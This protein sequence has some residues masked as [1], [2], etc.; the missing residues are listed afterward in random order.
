MKRWACS[1]ICVVVALQLYA[2]D[3]TTCSDSHFGHV[4]RDLVSKGNRYYM[5]SDREGIREVVDS[6]HGF[7]T[8]R[9]RS[10]RLSRM[11]SLEYVADWYKLCGNYHYENSFYDNTPSDSA[12][13]YY[14]KALEIY[15]SDTAFDEDLNCIPMIHRELAQL[16]YKQKNYQEAY[17]HT[18][19][20]Y[21]A[22][23]EALTHDVI[24]EDDA[25]YLDIQTQ[26]ALCLARMGDTKKALGMINKMTNRYP[27]ADEMYGEALRKKAKILMLQEENGGKKKRAAALKCYRSFFSLKKEDALARFMGMSSR[28]REQ[29][30][31]RIRPFVTDCYRLEDAD[32]G[33]LYDVTLFAKGLLL[34]LNGAGGGRQQ[35]HTT[36]Q[37][38][39][40]RLKPDACAIEFVQY[41]KYGQQQMA[42]LVLKKTGKPVFVKM[43]A[44]D[45]VWNYIVADRTVED[46]LQR[47][48]KGNFDAINRVYNDSTGIY[49][50]IWNQE[51]LGAIG[52]T[53]RVYFAPDGY[54][55]RIAIEY[56]L[57]QEARQW[58][59][60]RLTSTRRL[61]DKQHVTDRCQAL[62]IGGVDFAK[63][64]A[65][66]EGTNDA[67]A[68]KRMVNNLFTPLN[69][70]K[71]EVESILKDRANP[72]DSLLCGEWA[73]EQTFR[74]LCGKYPVIHVSAHGEYNADAPLGTDIKA[75]LTD[76]S[77]SE[78]VIV[79]AGVNKTLNDK[80]FDP[81]R[82]QDGILSAK[83]LSTLDMKGVQLVVLACCETGLGMV[84]ADGVFGIQR[85]L[86]N[87]GVGAIVMTL[88]E[89]DDE[90]T[91]AFMTTFH[92]KICEGKSIGCAF[93]ETREKY[94]AIDDDL[95]NQPCYLDVFVLVD[96]L[97]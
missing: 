61:M 26:M 15:E 3:M 90:A 20:A 8:M 41:E 95:I 66:V 86:K 18:K 14:Q 62:I 51:L 78:S 2:Q 54:I 69:Q 34:Q 31:M 93:R 7:M 13:W 96:A 75:C 23:V 39:Q 74:K 37:M 27:Q 58:E 89:A 28:E 64:N 48:D 30:W 72:L 80:T 53:K 16:Y 76:E 88:W 10:G 60:F 38:I 9:S 22:F 81:Q 1:I 49:R 82:I 35:I 68:Y 94:H 97:E 24:A 19:L 36:W 91:T 47:T 77:L 17:H 92:Q 70:S 46:R 6:I 44:P 71:A 25:D 83:E 63:A 79:L 33:F 85:G 45:S 40:D 67:V 65:Y 12:L 73:A 56:M 21:D 42:A 59:I 87:A 5:M 43:A 84:S 55:H 52:D 50:L 32:A 11:D 4:M 57:P 29:Y